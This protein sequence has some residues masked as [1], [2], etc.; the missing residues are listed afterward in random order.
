MLSIF[1]RVLLGVGDSL[2][3]GCQRRIIDDRSDDVRL[4]LACQCGRSG[5]VN[6]AHKFDY[7]MDANTHS[8]AV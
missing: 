8:F 3:F 2:A 6:L 7:A 5:V 1:S 4:W